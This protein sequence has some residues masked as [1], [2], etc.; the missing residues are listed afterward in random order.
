MNDK[1]EFYKDA[2]NLWRWRRIN[3]DGN[4]VEASTEGYKHQTVC[5]KN[6]RCVVLE[7]TRLF[8]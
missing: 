8:F 5:L 4:I 1:W 2:E 6:A 7:D 3:T